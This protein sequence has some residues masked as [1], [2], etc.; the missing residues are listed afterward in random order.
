MRGAIELL[1]AVSEPLATV[2]LHTLWQGLVIAC[3]VV[4]VLRRIPAERPNLRYAAALAGLLGIILAGLLTWGVLGYTPSA[5]SGPVPANN[6]EPP[7]AFEA[8]AGV[9]AVRPHAAA[10]PQASSPAAARS[11]AFTRVLIPCWLAGVALMLFRVVRLMGGA[12]RLRREC[13]PLPD[14]PTAVAALAQVKAALGVSRRVALLVADDLAGPV[15]MGLFWPAILLPASMATGLPPEHIRAVLAHELAHIRRYDYLVNFVQLVIEALLY[16]NP[17]VWW[18]SRQVRIEREACCDALAARALGDA[19]DYAQALTRI[20]GRVHA[21]ATLASAAQGFAP[22]PQHGGLL[23]R[24][25]RLLSPGYRPRL[26]LRW[27]SLAAGVLVTLAVLFGLY[28]SSRAGVALAGWFL[29][30]EERIEVMAELKEKYVPERTGEE[31]DYDAVR[32][33]GRIIT[34][35]GKPLPEGRHMYAHTRRGSHSISEGVSVDHET[36]RFHGLHAEG[37]THIFAEFPGYAPAMLGPIHGDPEEPIEDLEFRLEPDHPVTIRFVTPQ[38]EPVPNVLVEGG[39][40]F[41]KHTASLR[42]RRESNAQGEIQ[43]A[44]AADPVAMTLGAKAEGFQE[45]PRNSLVIQPDSTFESVLLPDVP[46]QGEVVDHETGQPVEG[47]EVRIVFTRGKGWRGAGPEGE[48]A[49]ITDSAGRFVLRGLASEYRH[50]FLVRALGYGGEVVCLAPGQPQPLRARL[51]RRYLEGAI[52]GDLSLLKQ[53]EDGGGPVIE[54]QTKLEIPLEHSSHLGLATALPVSVSGGEGRFRIDDLW[55]GDVTIMA[56]P[57]SV[58]LSVQEPVVDLVIDLAPEQS[59]TARPVIFNLLVP[60]GAPPAEG[61]LGISQSDELERRFSGREYLHVQDGQTTTAVNAPVRIRIDASELTGYIAT[62]LERD[63]R[64]GYFR[65]GIEVPAGT[66]PL[67]IDVAL[68]RAGAIHGRV[69]L[70]DGSPARDA[71]LHVN[72]HGEGVAAWPQEYFCGT[73]DNVQVDADGRFAV[74]PL[75]LGGQVSIGASIAFAR[76]KKEVRP[77]RTHPVIQVRLVIPEGVDVPIRVV[78]PQGTPM[79]EMGLM[80]DSPG[81]THT[82]IRTDA[83]GRYVLRGADPDQEYFIQAQ[84]VSRY[85]YVRAQVP[86]DGEE[87]VVRLQ[88]PGLCVSGTV[89]MEGTGAPVANVRVNADAAY[90]PATG[91]FKQYRVEAVT[92]SE[93]RFAFTNL[94]E[95]DFNIRVDVE[96]ARFTTDIPGSPKQFTAGQPEPIDILIRPN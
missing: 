14:N 16:F 29:S 75:P 21:G 13:R 71:S 56:G 57:K 20:G 53:G 64:L 87:M 62:P 92:D 6:G 7:N 12:R 35:D 9:P 65:H 48:L 58:R 55:A 89:R 77:T 17:A 81:C 1:A 59:M 76:V 19:A 88:K 96:S 41:L 15:A 69:V 86:F 83:E 84:P 10:E 82:G 3:A 50:Y 93:G 85:Q 33:S 79:P 43:L 67:V 4:V 47:A 94:C 31:P 60:E 73:S 74:L 51:G 8:D 22:E 36:G 18:L 45:S 90:D 27:Y 52:R 2:L 80:V 5:E 28:Q 40:Q 78:D 68:E 34:Y 91:A 63:A 72:V 95:G 30:D 39:Y 24:I 11:M 66:E 49:S 25:R 38:G 61:R 44:Q 70:P 32:I 46:V 37:E 54:Y 26:C 42:I 23:E